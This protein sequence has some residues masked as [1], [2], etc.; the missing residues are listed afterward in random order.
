M[1]NANQNGLRP[2]IP[3][4]S[5]GVT[6]GQL[7]I[8]GSLIGVAEHDAAAGDPVTIDTAFCG[9]FPKTSAL[10][11]AVGD[12]LYYDSTAKVVNKTSSG[13]TL[14][15]IAVDVSANPSSYARLKLGAT[16]V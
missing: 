6:S 14:V 9:D 15:G 7:V 2:T 1:K 8:V 13:N 10:A 11:I 3:A 4:P 5:G 12:K 16:T